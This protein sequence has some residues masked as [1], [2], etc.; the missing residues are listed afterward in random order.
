MP[1]PTL[2]LATISRNEDTVTVRTKLA[3]A[4]P[5]SVRAHIVDGELVVTA[6]THIR[7]AQR[8]AP[9]ERHRLIDLGP[10]LRPTTATRKP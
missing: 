10:K 8:T 9:P 7:A 2:R 1:T 6:R 3:D 4:D 5:A